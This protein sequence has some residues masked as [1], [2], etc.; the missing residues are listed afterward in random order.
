M[1]F[2]LNSIPILFSLICALINFLEDYNYIANKI[3]YYLPFF[4]T[5]AEWFVIP[6]YLLTVAIYYVRKNYVKWIVGT[7]V[8]NISSLVSIIINYVCWGIK[9]GHLYTPDVETV[10]IFEGSIYISTFIMIFGMILYKII[11]NRGRA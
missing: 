1:F 3:M 8:I 2:V 9:T 4:Q 7:L 10:I 6:I 11:H 5:L